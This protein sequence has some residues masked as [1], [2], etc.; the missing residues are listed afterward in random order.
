MCV[1]VGVCVFQKLFCKFSERVRTSWRECVVNMLTASSA[2]SEEHTYT[3]VNNMELNWTSQMQ[4][5]ES[6]THQQLQ[7]L[8]EQL[9][10]SKKVCLSGCVWACEEYNSILMVITLIADLG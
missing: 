5:K 9:E 8:R 6:H 3:L 4:Q 10:Q 2:L 7:M 1:W